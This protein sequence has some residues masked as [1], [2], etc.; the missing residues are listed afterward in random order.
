MTAAGGAP[1]TSLCNSSQ[2]LRERYSS[3][4]SREDRGPREVRLAV[5]QDDVRDAFGKLVTAAMEGQFGTVVLGQD[6]LIERLAE[7][8]ADGVEIGVA[9]HLNQRQDKQRLQ[10]DG[11]RERP[12]LRKTGW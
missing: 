4:N 7:V 2:G 9:A 8:A 11:D 5:E 3:W 6:A 10:H 12:A 1:L